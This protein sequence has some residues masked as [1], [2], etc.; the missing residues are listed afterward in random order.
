MLPA[1]IRPL[2]IELANFYHFNMLAFRVLE[3]RQDRRPPIPFDR[4]VVQLHKS[5][6]A[7]RQVAPFRSS[8]SSQPHHGEM[9]ARKDEPSANAARDYWIANFP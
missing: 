3:L 1:L 2:R 9:L 8:E 5:S 4:L 6:K 7:P